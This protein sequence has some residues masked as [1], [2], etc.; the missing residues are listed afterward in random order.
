MR[1]LWNKI[2]VCLGLL[3][4]DWFVDGGVNGFWIVYDTEP[5]T[6]Y[7]EP[8]TANKSRTKAVS[9]ALEYAR[10]IL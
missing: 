7:H 5:E 2:R 10:S 8:Q 3:P 1:R 6:G 4:I 9:E